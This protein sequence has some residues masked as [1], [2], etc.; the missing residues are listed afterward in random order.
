MGIDDFRDDR[1]AD[2]RQA[3]EATAETA[4]LVC[5]DPPPGV[6]ARIEAGMIWPGYGN[7]LRLRGARAVRSILYPDLWVIAA[8]VER[9]DLEVDDYAGK[10]DYTVWHIRMENPDDASPAPDDPI[11]RSNRAARG[12]RYPSNSLADTL[13]KLAI[14]CTAAALSGA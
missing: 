6:V 7:I 10:E 2:R 8:D 14:G 1:E 13:D 5:R 4:A 3:Q 12:V 11:T 9:I